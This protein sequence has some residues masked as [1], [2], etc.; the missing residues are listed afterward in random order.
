M[1]GEETS[2]SRA[3]EKKPFYGTTPTSTPKAEQNKKFKRTKYNSSSVPSLREVGERGVGK[4]PPGCLWGLVGSWGLPSA[5]S[6]HLCWDNI[7]TLHIDYCE[8]HIADI[9]GSGWE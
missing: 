4:Y 6:V 1:Q 2:I 5:W 9:L 8:L 7:T 3:A